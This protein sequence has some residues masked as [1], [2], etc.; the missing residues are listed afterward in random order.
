MLQAKVYVI[1]PTKNSARTLERCLASISRQTY[2]QIEVIIVDAY[3]ADGTK[4][5]AEKYG[6]KIIQTNTERANAKNY[7]LQIAD[8]EYVLFLDS[9]M[10]V[11]P[12]V[13][14]ECVELCIDDICAITIPERSVGN[15][16]WVKVRDFERS[17][18]A[19]TEVES[20]RFFKRSTALSVG[21]FDED[22]TFFEESTLPN[23]LRATGKLRN[24]RTDAVILH[25]END[26]N[27]IDWCRK[28]SKYAQTRRIYEERYPKYASGQTSLIERTVIYF[29]GRNKIR[30]LKNPI[31]AFG[32]LVL[33]IS[34]FISIKIPKER[35]YDSNHKL[36][37]VHRV[38]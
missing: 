28:K 7:G 1:I 13:I 29:R 24:K 9:D 18:Y 11:T 21:G 38:E 20:P 2:K 37:K 30:L 35:M 14:K 16:F 4:E 34:E 36:K 31:L 15:G 19:N 10:E 6:A 27:L 8:G 32:V 3:S 12:N 33:K 5:I 25:I 26:L 22:L 17:F 23:K